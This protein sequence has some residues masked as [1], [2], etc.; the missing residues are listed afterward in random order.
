MTGRDPAPQDGARIRARWLVL[1]VTLVVAVVAALVWALSRDGTTEADEGRP[2]VGSTP[3]PTADASQAPSP[4]STSREPDASAPAVA[5]T[6]DRTE[7]PE[8]VR[9]P[10]DDVADLGGGVRVEVVDVEAVQGEARGPGQ[11]AGPALRL[12]VEVV[13]RSADPVDLTASVV[14]VTYGSDAVPAGDLAGPGARFLP[15]EVG[16]GE[17]ARGRYVFAVPRAE[18]D[19]IRV[20]FSYGAETPSA[21]FVSDR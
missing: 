12:T 7:R 6:S 3:S 10:L 16:P 14:T 13:N 21:V 4:G 15:V 17:A 19:T 20:V 11:T 9:V 2:A 1:A 18:R 5:P 8:P